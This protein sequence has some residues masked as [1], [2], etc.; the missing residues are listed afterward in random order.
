ML[1]EKFLGLKWLG[2]NDRTRR[3]CYLYICVCVCVSVHSVYTYTWTCILVSRKWICALVI[4]YTLH[5]NCLNPGFIRE[6]WRC[7]FS[8][9]AAAASELAWRC[10]PHIIYRLWIVVTVSAF[11]DSCQSFPI[12]PRRLAVCARWLLSSVSC[13]ST[14]T[15]FFVA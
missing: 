1:D 13:L 12:A 15:S 9:T 8:V 10:D 3:F 14:R 5:V 7:S 11:F 6:Y 4:L 2:W